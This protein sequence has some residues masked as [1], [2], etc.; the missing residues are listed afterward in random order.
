MKHFLRKNIK[1][2]KLDE[3]KASIR[4][5]WE[6]KVTPDKCWKYISN[7]RKAVPEVICH[8]GQKTGF[9]IFPLTKK[10]K[11]LFPEPGFWICPWTKSQ[12]GSFQS[13]QLFQREKI[14]KKVKIK[15]EA[16]YGPTCTSSNW[17]HT[18]IHHAVKNN[19]KYSQGKS[20]GL[21]YFFSCCSLQDKQKLS[22]EIPVQ[23]KE[24]VLH[25]YVCGLEE[26]S[27]RCLDCCGSIM[28]T[29]CDYKIHMCNLFHERHGC[30]KIYHKSSQE[31]FITDKNANF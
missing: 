13:H 17:H 25:S 26:A 5:S 6:I 14:E 7:M 20:A 21:N 15:I 4:L 29:T 2:K 1:P 28:C 22:F 3:V 12:N 8:S 9:W 24:V 23:Q 11:W 27:F 19:A 16:Q 30:L 18:P 10:S 31:N